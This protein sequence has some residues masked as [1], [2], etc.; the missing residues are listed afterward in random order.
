[1]LEAGGGVTVNEFSALWQI[2]SDEVIESCSD[3]IRPEHSDDQKLLERHL[4]EFLPL[5]RKFLVLGGELVVPV[6]K[7]VWSLL[8]KLL[9]EV[10]EALDLVQLLE[11]KPSEIRKPLLERVRDIGPGRAVDEVVHL[12]LSVLDGHDLL[13]H[14][15]EGEL[16]SENEMMSHEETSQYPLI[17]GH[18]DDFPQSEDSRLLLFESFG[19][20]DSLEEEGGE[21]LERVLVHVVNNA[22]FDEHE[23]EHG[24]LGS[25]SS[26]DLSGKVDLLLCLDGNDLLL[27]DLGGGLLGDLERLNER[28]VL[29][30]RFWIGIGELLQE[31]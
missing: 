12:L 6:L 2:V 16:A 21:R 14:Q 17:D 7:P 4:V 15:P 31:S 23:I 22:E 25:H 28:G 3:S 26:V 24:T 1:M 5:K 27:L 8:L 11:S 19:L 29:Q 20:V 30:N 10:L 18:S 9:N 13:L